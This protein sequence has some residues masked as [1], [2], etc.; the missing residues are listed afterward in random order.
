MWFTTYTFLWVL[1]TDVLSEILNLGPE[2]LVNKP[3]RSP[4][5]VVLHGYASRKSS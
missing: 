5:K 4:S 3:L 1:N 2:Q